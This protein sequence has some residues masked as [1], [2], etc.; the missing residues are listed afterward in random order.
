MLDEIEINTTGPR[1]RQALGQGF[2]LVRH[3]ISETLLDDAYGGLAEFFALPAAV[4]ATCVVPGT[5]GQ[6]GYTPAL[7]ETAANTT[8]ADWKELFHWGRTLPD[9]HPLATRYPARYPRPHWPDD[10]V[11]GLGRV[12]S[13]L[14]TAM[15]DFQLSVVD[16][17]SD[18][19]G[20][21]RGFFRDMLLDGP[22]ANRASWYP[23]MSQAPGDEH[24]WAVAHQDFDLVTML[25]RATT[26]GLEVQLDG[27]WVRVQAP[28][29]YAVINAGMVLDRLT[30]G[31]VPAATH[32]VVATADQREGRL[33]IVQFCHPV[34]STVLTPLTVD[35]GHPRY[36]TVT[37]AD[38][39][40]LTM[41]RINRLESA[42]RVPE[43]A[44]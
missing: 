6:S 25:P 33:S 4:K 13:A 41:Y 44:V 37:A 24:V 35:G 36:S 2:F 3:P 32:R 23:P 8:T 27:E 42:R 19:L 43:P 18:N 12:L 5:N 26:A 40:D 1:Q 7:V 22:V 34:P 14:H 29:G 20:V 39:F 11:P 21:P 31:A 9:T 16:T 17:I 15:F 28:P 10:L 38:L 30:N